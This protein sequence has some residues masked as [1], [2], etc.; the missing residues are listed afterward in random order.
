MG[1][2]SKIDKNLRHMVEEVIVSQDDIGVYLK[3]PYIFSTTSA[4][5]TFFGLEECEAEAWAE[6][7]ECIA[8]EAMAIEPETWDKG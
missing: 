4:S 8:D 1:Y 5:T 3:R 7:N 6:L 2:I